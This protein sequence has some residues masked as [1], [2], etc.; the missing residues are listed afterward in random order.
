MVQVCSL[1]G[2]KA[3]TAL[4]LMSLHGEIENPADVGIF[5]D[6]GQE[7]QSTYDTI[8]YLQKFG[9]SK[10]VPVH[11]VKSDKLPEIWTNALNPTSKVGDIPFHTIDKNGKKTMLGKYCTGEYKRDPIRKFIR[12]EFNATFKSPVS[13]WLGYTMDEATRRKDSDRKYEI[14][15]YPL[16]EKRLYR[17]HC[18][19]YLKELGLETVQ[20]SACIFCPYR[21]DEEYTEMP[22]EE[23]QRAIQ[24]EEEV[25]EARGIITAEKGT[26][27]PLRIHPSL[28]PLSTRPFENN[29]QL[30]LFD[31]MCDGGS[32]WT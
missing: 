32:C 25:N 18:E 9:N 29:K 3:S 1:G 14:R 30:G 8:E 16:L 23:I 4:F 19:Q 21:R 2:G 24:F 6:T 12:N 10:G 15:R 27:A 13:I 5:A 17:Y 22:E 11:I 26:E 28:E 31:E 20:R 7:R